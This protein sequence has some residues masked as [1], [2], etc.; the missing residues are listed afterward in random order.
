MKKIKAIVAICILVVGIGSIGGCKAGK[1]DCPKF[2][3]RTAPILEQVDA[4]EELAI[5]ETEEACI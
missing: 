1:C 5:K 4:P 2:S 3:K